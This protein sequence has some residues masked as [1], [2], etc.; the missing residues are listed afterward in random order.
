MS[1]FKLCGL[2]CVLFC[3]AGIGVYSARR[4]SLRVESLEA[5]ASLFRQLESLVLYTADPLGKL[6]S[7]M[8]KEFPNLPFLRECRLLIE[9][10]ISFPTAF[11]AAIR[12]TA[13]EMGLRRE[14][15]EL[16]CQPGS[17]LGKTDLKGQQS[18]YQL[19][20]LRVSER[21]SLAREDAEK[22]GK[23]YRSVGLLGGVALVLFAL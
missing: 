2:L 15:I 12:Q 16:L 11:S 13:F 8:E 10:K 4:L 19:L 3:C 14:D 18:L 6:F 5:L 22:K 9:G 23:I 17:Q 21:L 20:E 1:F 7:H